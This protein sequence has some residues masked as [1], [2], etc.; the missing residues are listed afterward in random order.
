MKRFSIR[1]LALLTASL[2][3]LTACGCNKQTILSFNNNPFGSSNNPTQGYTEILE[4][5]VKNDTSYGDYLKK[6]TFLNNYNL[7]YEYAGSFR[8]T[9][10][11]GTLNNLDLPDDVETEFSTEITDYVYYYKTELNLKSTYTVDGTLGGKLNEDYT[12]D[13]EGKVTYDDYVINE[14]WFLKSGYSLAP[15]YAQ[16]K[17]KYTTL[18]LDE[19]VNVVLNEYSYKTAYDNDEYETTIKSG[20]QIKENDCDYDF[21]CVID[22]AQ[23]LFAIRCLNITTEQSVSIPVVSPAYDKPQTLNFTN[24]TDD[25]KS[26]TINGTPAQIPVKNINFK[27][28]A[29]YN[30]GLAHHALI[31]KSSPAQEIPNKALL[32]EY[33]APITTYGV[34]Y[35]M[36]AMVYTLTNA[37][38]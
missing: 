30:T 9:L 36:G 15:I 4:Y 29:T 32:I 22:N 19:K 28:S 8:T 24:S 34:F 14:V 7:S 27:V 37:T 21:K 12:Q 20:D 18:T 31:Q 5:T 2:I 13:S 25:T 38:Y 23:L 1:F 17:Q 11:V 10:K 35:N 26:T 33:A 16:G 6:D 3:A